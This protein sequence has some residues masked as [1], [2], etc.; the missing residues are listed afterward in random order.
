MDFKQQKVISHSSVI[1]GTQDQGAWHV[2]V[3]GVGCFLLPRWHLVS[4]SSGGKNSC[5]N[6]T[7]M[8]GKRVHSCV[9]VHNFI[10]EDSTLMV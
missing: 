4:Q 2:S 3:K 7:E 6:W 1:Q 5:P 10:Y 9:E 8:E